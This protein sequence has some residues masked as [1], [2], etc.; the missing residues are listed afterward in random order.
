MIE[1]SMTVV[2]Q[3]KDSCTDSDSQLVDS[4]SD[5]YSQQFEASLEFGT[6]IGIATVPDEENWF[7]RPRPN[8]DATTPNIR[9]ANRVRFNEAD[10]LASDRDGVISISYKQLGEK[11]GGKDSQC[12][13]WDNP[14][15]PE[16]Y[17]SQDADRMVTMWKEGTIGQ[18]YSREYETDTE[19][20]N[21]EAVKDTLENISDENPQVSGNILPRKPPILDISTVDMLDKSSDNEKM[22]ANC[23][24]L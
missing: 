5:I 22:Q 6:T 3:C 21:Y 4:Y 1:S 19:D 8:P 12:S 10:E 17:L 24:V 16:G 20:D 23:C 11:I 9:K 18:E 2:G 15:Q 7:T 14:F 13:E